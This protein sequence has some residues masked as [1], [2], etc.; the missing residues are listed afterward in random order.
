MP[1]ATKTIM[2]AAIAAA[3]V[4]AQ[5]P[6]DTQFLR[7]LSDRVAETD[8]PH[9]GA[10]TDSN[11]D[12][13]LQTDGITTAEQ[14][15]REIREA[16]ARGL[17]IAGKV[18]AFETGMAGLTINWTRAAILRMPYESAHMRAEI[19]KLREEHGGL[20]QE[21]VEKNSEMPNFTRFYLQFREPYSGILSITAITV[22]RW[23]DSLP[24]REMIKGS[25]DLIS[26]RCM[27]S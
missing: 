18:T 6:A 19:E 10:T 4:S 24:N 17:G 27:T 25:C 20:I 15:N 23:R 1:L 26:T 5:M 14:V 13:D 16:E 9:M 2:M 22:S 8:D 11:D 7:N 21:M 12:P 3:L